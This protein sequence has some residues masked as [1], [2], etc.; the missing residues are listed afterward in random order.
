MDPQ[1]YTLKIISSTKSNTCFVNDRGISNID[2]SD[3][4][5]DKVLAT[6]TQHG[7]FVFREN[8]H[9]KVLVNDGNLTLTKYHT[10]N[11]SG[12]DKY[13]TM[14]SELVVPCLIIKNSPS[15]RH[16]RTSGINTS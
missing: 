9:S 13:D 11:Q 3:T 14:T 12:N 1:S 6:W 2:F 10:L 15:P 8:Y 16:R 5:V 7:V 4:V